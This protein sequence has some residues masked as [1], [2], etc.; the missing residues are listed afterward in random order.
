MKIRAARLGRPGRRARSTPP[1]APERGATSCRPRGSTLARAL[2]DLAKEGVLGVDQPVG[3]LHGG[4]DD[5]LPPDGRS[6]SAGSASS[7]VSTNLVTASMAAR[8]PASRDPSTSSESSEVRST[9]LTCSPL[10]SQP[11]GA[12]ECPRFCGPPRCA[13]PWSLAWVASLADVGPVTSAFAEP[14]GRHSLVAGSASR[15][16]LAYDRTPARRRCHRYRTRT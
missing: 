7:T 14:L 13:R 6:P 11:R 4:V 16:P 10:S 1:A 5:L 9:A 3:H 8:C 15:P 12:C 2:Y